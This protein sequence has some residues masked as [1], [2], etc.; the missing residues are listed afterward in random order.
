MKVRDLTKNSPLY[1]NSCCMTRKTNYIILLLF[2][3]IRFWF[4]TILTIFLLSLTILTMQGWE[5]FLKIFYHLK[6]PEKNEKRGKSG[7]PSLHGILSLT[8]LC[9]SL[10]IR[11]LPL[12][13]LLLS[14][15]IILLSL[16]HQ[17]KC[18]PHN[19]IPIQ[20]KKLFSQCR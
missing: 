7:F 19:H 12:T 16:C 8:I 20:R 1:F 9:L 18:C 6:K 3:K 17:V 13:I 5:F 10:T 4:F 15:T 2:L 11:L 14:F